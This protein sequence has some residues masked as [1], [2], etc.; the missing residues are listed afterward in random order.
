MKDKPGQLI[1]MRISFTERI[2]FGDPKYKPYRLAPIDGPAP[3]ILNVG[4]R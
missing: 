2:Y 1:V 4:N 3:I